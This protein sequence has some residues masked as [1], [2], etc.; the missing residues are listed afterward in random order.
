[1]KFFSKQEIRGL[2]DSIYLERWI[3]LQC[4]WFSIRLH[5]FHRSDEDVMHDHPWWFCSLILKG[6]YFEET[7]HESGICHCGE[8]MATHSYYS[9]PGYDAKDMPETRSKWYGP[10]RVLFRRATH[11][12]RVVLDDGANLENFEATH[13]GTT[14]PCWTL[15]VTGPSRREWGFYCPNGWRSWKEFFAKAGCSDA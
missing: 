11:V 5:K 4:P 1:M 13:P 6:G 3:L 14:I 12:H 7:M 15:V 9:H 10:G 2:G 8:E